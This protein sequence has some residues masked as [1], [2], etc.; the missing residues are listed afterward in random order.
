MSRKC[1][2]LALIMAA[3]VAA[4]AHAADVPLD[5]SKLQTRNVKAEALSFKG[6]NAVRVSDTAPNAAPDGARF[7]I[8]PETDFQDGVIEVD[9]TGDTAPG[10]DP[11]FRGFTGIAFRV[12]PE[13]D[14]YECFYLRPKNGRSE[15]QVQRNHSTQYI[16]VP[17]FTWQRLRQEFPSKYESYVD[18]VPGE[19]THVKIEVQG[20][21]ARLYVNG[22]QQPT[23]I[24]NDLK[25]GRSRG[26]VALWIGPGTIAHFSNLRITRPNP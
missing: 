13:G 12:A 9:L 14:S 8:V 21:K 11:F 10:A 1:I 2:C 20:E 26:A 19:W 5:A 3:A 6:K 7:A 16:S 25:R 15:D 24:V 18:L 4:G 22:A 17:N 23:L